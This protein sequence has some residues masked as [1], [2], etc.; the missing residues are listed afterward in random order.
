MV[1]YGQVVSATFIERPNRFVA[2]CEVNGQAETVHVKNTGRCKELLIPGV[3]VFLEEANATT[4]KT[5]YDLIAVMKKGQLINI[6]SQVPNKIF[7]EAIKKT[8][9][10]PTLKGNI[11]VLQKEVTYG[12]SRFDFYFET[13]QAE[14]GFVEIKGM[15]L[16]ENG[17]VSFPD[18]PTLRGL[19]H[20]NELGLAMTEGYLGFV[21]F[22][23]QMNQATYATIN[24]NMQ[25]ALKLAIQTMMAE[26]LQVLA[27]TCEVL[28]D[29]ISLA[30]AIPFKI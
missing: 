20:V 24:E 2:I 1:Q 12:Q 6:D 17:V 23:V 16:E 4:R 28:E 26:G 27:Y 10:L 3:E 29:R 13:D 7:A 18:A 11:Q 30:E 22:I 21:V 5:K 9:T 25:P 19:K 8:P 14:K 15:T